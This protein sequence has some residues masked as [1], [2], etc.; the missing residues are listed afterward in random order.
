MQEYIEKIRQNFPILETKVNGAP[1][2]YLDNAAT[3]QKPDYVI[4]AI[5]DYYRAS[6]ANVHRGV[7]HLSQK[8]TKLYEDSRIKIQKFINAKSE[9]EC[10]F[11]SGTTEAINLVASS[12]GEKFINEGDEIIITHM[13]HH[14]NIV[15][16]QLLCERKKAILK[17]IPIKDNGE[18]DLITIDNLLTD[19]VKILAIVHVSNSLGT[20]NPVKEII[21]KAKQKNIPVLIDGAQAVANLKVDMQDLDC[22]FYVFSGHKLYGPTGI[23]VLYAKEKWLNAMPPYKGGGDMIMK[24][25]INDGSTYNKPPYKFE[26]GTPN[27]A[28]AIGLG[29]TIDYLNSLDLNI[30]REHKE[31]LLH[32]A[33]EK[34]QAIDGIKILGTAKNKIG[35]ISFLCDKVHAHDLGTIVDNYGV[36]I[37]AGHHCTMPV[38]EHFNVAATCRVSIAMY[39][40]KEE[41]DKLCETLLIAIKMFTRD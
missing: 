23:G 41:I 10:V 7:H 14:S 2:V 18:L 8:A 13:E 4:N 16:W 29:A 26:A 33:T 3:T 36:A 37:R 30:I 5:S 21:E 39:N 15:P 9:K 22:D 19:K 38:M 25:S 27:I 35:V 40:T 12:F 6:N 17:A 1:L 11:T 34:L 32:Y 31:N 24:V 20:I 28:Q